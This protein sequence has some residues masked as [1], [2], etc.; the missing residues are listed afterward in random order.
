M[1]PMV[2]EIKSTSDARTEL[3]SYVRAFREDPFTEPVIFGSHRKAEGV[4]M[5]VELYE[6]LL[7]YAEDAEIA[8]LIRRRVADT[9]GER[10]TLDEMLTRAGS[11]DLIL[12]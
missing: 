10:L 1:R 12:D 7:S 11:A 3:S 9:D 2:Q 8:A 6:R 4:V 5:S